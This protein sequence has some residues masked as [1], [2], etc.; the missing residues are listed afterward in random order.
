VLSLESDKRKSETLRALVSGCHRR[1]RIPRATGANTR[2]PGLTNHSGRNW[3]RE[4]V[5][6]LYGRLGAGGRT[7]GCPA[8]VIERKFSEEQ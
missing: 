5:N 8:S 4:Q 7:A 6:T 3:C 1:S 2:L